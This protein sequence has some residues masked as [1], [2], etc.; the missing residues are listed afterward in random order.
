M[1]KKIHNTQNILSGILT[2][3]SD[4]SKH[5]QPQL[6]SS[7]IGHPHSLFLEYFDSILRQKEIEKRP[8]LFGFSFLPRI[9]GR[10]LKKCKGVQL[11]SALKQSVLYDF[12]LAFQV[13]GKKHI[14]SIHPSN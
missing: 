11:R 5:D 10:G 1:K 3:L 12:S 8:I 9:L 7:Y 13:W 6:R 4:K 14:E 2:F